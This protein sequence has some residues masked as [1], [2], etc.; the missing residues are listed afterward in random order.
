MKGKS[1]NFSGSNSK[2]TIIF[3]L[4][5]ILIIVVV[6]LI[7]LN[8]N[9]KSSNKE[10]FENN[11]NT[12]KNSD[13]SKT[14]NSAKNVKTD[15]SENNTTYQFRTARAGHGMAVGTLLNSNVPKDIA[16]KQK[17]NEVQCPKK[18]GKKGF[19]VCNEIMYEDGRK[20][21]GCGCLYGTKYNDRLNLFYDD[22]Y[23]EDSK[24]N[25]ND[26]ME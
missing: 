11:S 2:M 23:K 19:W 18:N 9:K 14:S 21:T 7:C 24:N 20:R 15:N 5:A 25:S 13:S 6:V 17:K 1:P 4:V 16:D 3:V 8:L 26:T 22:K 10:S 12:A